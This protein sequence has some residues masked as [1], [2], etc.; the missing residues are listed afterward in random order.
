M[1]RIIG[2]KHLVRFCACE[3]LV[4]GS[5]PRRAVLLILT[6]AGLQWETVLGQV[7]ETTKESSVSSNYFFIQIIF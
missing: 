5:R 3:Q 7:D 2:K 4:E 1:L 6:R